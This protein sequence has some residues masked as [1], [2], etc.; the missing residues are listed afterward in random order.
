MTSK[1]VD[2]KKNDRVFYYSEPTDDMIATV[3]QEMK[4]PEDWN[5][6][7]DSLW[8]RFKAFWIFYLTKVYVYFYVPLKLHV[9]IKNKK[10]IKKAKGSG[11]VLYGNHVY[12]YSDAFSP[13]II[14]NKRIYT[15]VSPANF[16]IPVLGKILPYLGGL[17]LGHT[18]EL[19]QRFNDAIDKRLQ[20]KRCLVIF[21]EAHV[22]PYYTGIRDF[23]D[24]SFKYPIRNNV[25]IF[26]FV[27]TFQKRKHSD[28]PKA[29]IYVDG[30]F[31]P[32]SKLS[33]EEN[34]KYLHDEIYK[35]FVKYNKYNT[36]EY[37]KYIKKKDKKK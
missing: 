3:K 24:G 36:Y 23:I 37:F 33:M 13:A 19:K 7:P 18:E 20:Q 32:N 22:W 28:K 34:K 16:G 14:S 26:S 12:P 31:Y 6:A 25:P 30:P 11:F 35:S 17:P 5:Y 29:T 2:K 8:W 15:I 27:T 4:I 10:V 1:E 21:P 9:R